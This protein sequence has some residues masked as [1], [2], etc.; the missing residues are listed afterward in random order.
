M[1]AIGLMFGN[2][3]AGIAAAAMPFPNTPPPETSPLREP[4]TIC[5]AGLP[6]DVIHVRVFPIGIQRRIFPS[7]NEI[8]ERGGDS[9]I[10][11][12]FW[13]KMAAGLC[14]PNVPAADI[15]KDDFLPRIVVFVDGE[16]DRQPLLLE[17]PDWKDNPQPVRASL[18]GKMI[19][20]PAAV[21]RKLLDYSRAGW[22]D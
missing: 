13:Q 5:G 6:R 4:S 14:E 10:T 1:S 22:R 16:K 17:Y 7:P 9:W 19:S 15:A 12:S 11:R 18:N 8:I 20:V 2:W 3:L 21:V